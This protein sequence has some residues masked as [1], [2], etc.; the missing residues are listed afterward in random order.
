MIKRKNKNQEAI[1]AELTEA[2]V[3]NE[4]TVTE[5]SLD[6]TETEVD[7]NGDKKER[8]R[9]MWHR[10]II[11]A[12][13]CI[14]MVALW[15]C[16]IHLFVYNKILTENLFMIGFSI[17]A[18]IIISILMTVF[19]NKAN[20][21]LSRVIVIF[22]YIYFAAQYI[23]YCVFGSFFSMFQIRMGGDAV[24]GFWKETLS[25]IKDNIG[26]LLLMLIPLVIFELCVKFKAVCLE[27]VKLK[28]FGIQAGSA[29]VAHIICVICICL[30]G[31]GTTTSFY[32]VY[33]GNTT[34]TDRSVEVLGVMTTSRLE[35]WHM[36]FGNL[37]NNLG[38]EVI[39]EIP[40]VEEKTSQDEQTVDYGKNIIDD[41]DFEYL[42]TVTNQSAIITLNDYFGSLEG[43]NK[44]EYT[45]MLKDYNLIVLTCESFAPYAINKEITPTL[46]KLATEGFIFENFYNSYPNN[47]TNG[48]YTVCM[49]N[50]PDL[51][52]SKSNA[53]FTN[54]VENYLPYALGNIYKDQRNI[55]AHAYH[56]YQGY[57]YNREN[58][59]PNMGYEFKSAGAGMEFTTSW[60]ASDYE[61]MVQSVDDYIDEE[62]F[63]AYY[64]TFSGHYRYDFD[65]NPMA[66]RNERKVQNLNYSEPVK[67]FLACHI[68]L[69]KA[70]EYLLERLEEK[71]IADKTAIVMTA[72][73][74]P[75][76]LKDEEYSELAG[77]EIDTEFEK[78]EN[79]L[80][81]WV[82]GLEE[83]I[84][85]DEYCS[86]VDVLPTILNLFGFDYDSRIL[87]GVDILDKD[88]VHL[89]ILNDGSFINEYV[90][91]N[92][93]TGE[94]TYL[95]DESKI[96]EGYVNSLVQLVKNKM[97]A[98]AAILNYDYYDFVFSN[99]GLKPETEETSSSA[100]EQ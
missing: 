68:E 56:N 55:Q 4:K 63:H 80:I 78:F 66:A 75:Y 83:P 19:P 5:A 54:S 46:Y 94:I 97:S 38:L 79:S 60:P 51:T 84:V 11:T 71:G 59:H 3:N 2:V 26:Y 89:G 22:L 49:G 31:T 33:F 43:T 21:V 6:T 65:I 47:T 98:S 57:Y 42:N 30:V 100:V 17:P 82:G 99:S 62:Q 32:D 10:R 53:S 45:G 93:S 40:E 29:L 35:L 37:D 69:D 81:F 20:K 12:V 88:A 16:G 70:M 61:M 1:S 67:A 73:H 64:M 77:K 23:Y 7:K 18:G 87:N 58:T 14:V 95:V 52:R 24:T 39:E 41:I 8:K 28:E 13:V 36:A 96:P 48:E 9:M 25:C 92:Q 90:K 76:G 74:F 27:R 91:V 44:N 15:E 34:T 86:T 50:F 85:I 72:D